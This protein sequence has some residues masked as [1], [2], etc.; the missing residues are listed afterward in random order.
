MFQLVQTLHLE[1][2]H[3]WQNNNMLVRILNDYSQF[4]LPIKLFA[5]NHKSKRKYIITMKYFYNE[6]TTKVVD[7]SLCKCQSCPFKFDT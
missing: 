1:T 5:T 2:F 3:L 6:A 7:Q 4:W